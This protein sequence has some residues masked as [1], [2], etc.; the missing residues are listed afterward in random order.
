[1]TNGDREHRGREARGL[2]VDGDERIA[3][4][5]V[6]DDGARL[7]VEARAHV[8]VS[9]RGNVDRDVGG[10]VPLLDDEQRV[11]ARRHLRGARQ[12]GAQNLAVLGVQPHGRARSVAVDLHRPQDGHQGQLHLHFLTDLQLDGVLLGRL[13]PRELDDDLVLAGTQPK[14]ARAVAPGPE[15]LAIEVHGGSRRIREHLEHGHVGGHA[16][17]GVLDDL[18]LLDARLGVEGLVVISIRVGRLA[19]LL[20]GARDVVEDVA[21]GDQAVGREVVL[22]RPL[23]V[24]LFVVVIA[25]LKLQ[26]RFV[27]E[28][29]GNGRVGDQQKGEDEKSAAHQLQEPG[30]REGHCSW[31]QRS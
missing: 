7:R 26:I 6:D 20:V 23:E 9:P 10:L 27:G 28:I 19:E 16:P 24:L 3:N 14:V 25:Q 12:R 5:G 17:D 21:V 15:V 11:P 13:V 22:E 2:L 1:M 30:D 8:E 18:A 31:L 4:V 29:V